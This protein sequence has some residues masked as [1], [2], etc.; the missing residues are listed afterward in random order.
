MSTV[1]CRCLEG[2]MRWTVN[3]Y[4]GL[5][6]MFNGKSISSAHAHSPCTMLQ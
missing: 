2:R 1:Y 4:A 3:K 6:K 5:M